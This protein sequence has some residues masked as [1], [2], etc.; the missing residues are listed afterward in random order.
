MQ[1]NWWFKQTEG[2]FGPL[3][4]MQKIGMK[5]N[6]HML[7]DVIEMSCKENDEEAVLLIRPVV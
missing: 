2:Q 5:N 4:L 6:V 3:C 7:F 1:E